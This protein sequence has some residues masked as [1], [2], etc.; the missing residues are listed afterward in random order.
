MEDL[1]TRIQLVEFEE[2]N[3]ILKEIHGMLLLLENL[4]SVKQ[5]IF[6]IEAATYA[7]KKFLELADM[8]KD[9]SLSRKRE[10]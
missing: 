6:P 8:I 4:K 7:I 2:I 1:E 5:T 3:E 9:E 10:I